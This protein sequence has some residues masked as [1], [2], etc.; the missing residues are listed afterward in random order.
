MHLP[1]LLLLLRAETALLLHLARHSWQGHA[2]FEHAEILGET[3]LRCHLLLALRQTRHQ[4]RVLLCVGRGVCVCVCVCVCILC[5]CYDV[6]CVVCLHVVCLLTAARRL[7]VCVCVVCCV[8][9]ACVILITVVL[10]KYGGP[11]RNMF[12]RVRRKTKVF[13]SSK[14]DGQ[15]KKG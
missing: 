2:H 11:K 6:C 14:N 15:K 3:R 13:R 4:L 10:K 8:Y 9:C 12:Q 7:C 5:I 1:P